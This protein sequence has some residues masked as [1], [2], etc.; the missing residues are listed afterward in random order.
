VTR[1]LR[2]CSY[3]GAGDGF[4]CRT[5]TDFLLGSRSPDGSFGFYETPAS[6]L[7]RRGGSVD[8]PISIQLAVTMQALWTLAEQADPGWRLLEQLQS[9]EDACPTPLR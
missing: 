2:A 6:I 3:A 8:S 9:K 1:C 7:E 4:G 5:A